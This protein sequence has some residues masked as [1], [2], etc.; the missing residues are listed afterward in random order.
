LPKRK[1]RVIAK[2]VNVKMALTF[3]AGANIILTILYRF[4]NEVFKMNG[5]MRAEEYA[6]LWDI[7]LRQVQ[8]LCKMGRIDGAVKFGTIWAIPEGSEKPTRTGELKP[9]RKSKQT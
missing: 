7:S 5:Y 4:L 1:F 9:G 2:T 6:K 3:I 8:Y